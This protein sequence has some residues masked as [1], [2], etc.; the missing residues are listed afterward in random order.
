[1][2]PN[3]A[4]ERARLSQEAESVGVTDAHRY[5]LP[6]HSHRIAII[7][8]ARLESRV[9]SKG[10]TVRSVRFWSLVAVV[11]VV[12]AAPAGS[13]SAAPRGRPAKQAAIK[14]IAFVGSFSGQA[15]TKLEQGSSTADIRASGKGTGTLIGAATISG[16]GTADSSQQPCPPFGGTGSIVG[17]KGTIFFSVVSGAKGCG[18]EG[19]HNFSLVGYLSVT[20]ATAALAKAKGQLRFTGSYSRDDGTF[21]IKLTG[22][23]TQPQSTTSRPTRAKKPVVVSTRTVRG[24]GRVLVDSRGRTLYMFVPD[25]HK[26]VTCLAGCAAVWPPLKL[27]PGAKAIARNGAKAPLLGSDPN[28]RGGR[29]VT[30]AHWPLY[31]YIGDHAA[32]SAAGQALNLNGGLWYALSP[33]GRVIHTKLHHT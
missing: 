10:A 7:T 13:A 25:K 27:A 14:K 32:G 16:T 9:A 31:T 4:G 18:D 33:T 15:S 26:R 20:R 11:A 5:A 8:E 21:Q 30:Y 3:Y 1:V 2:I 24:L 19:G 28:P 29:V 12:S 22:T 17:A 23:L 6:D